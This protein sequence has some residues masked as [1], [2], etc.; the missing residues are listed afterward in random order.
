[1][2][3]KC[4]KKDPKED[5]LEQKHRKN[6]R[7]NTPMIAMPMVQVGNGIKKGIYENTDGEKIDARVWESFYDKWINDKEKNPSPG[8][9]PDKYHIYNTHPEIFKEADMTI[10]VKENPPKM[11]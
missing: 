3:N 2:G 9:H 6:M 7:R 5:I 4:L 1:M 8:V 11:N 10:T